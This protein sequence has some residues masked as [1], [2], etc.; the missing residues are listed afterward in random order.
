[1]G[2]AERRP[3]VIYDSDGVAGIRAAPVQKV[4]TE[5]P[6]VPG[7]QA[8]SALVIDSNGWHGSKTNRAG[9]P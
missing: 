8:I 6:G 9:A 7:G 1:M 5:Y 2:R 3:S 4:G